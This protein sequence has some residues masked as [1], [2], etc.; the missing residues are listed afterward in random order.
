MKDSDPIL[1]WHIN[2]ALP[3]AMDI[4]VQARVATLITPNS[5]D[6]IYRQLDTNW[7]AWQ[8]Y[9]PG[10]K[11]ELLEDDYLYHPSVG[12]LIPAA[13]AWL[14]QEKIIVYRFQLICIVQPDN[15]FTVG[16]I[17]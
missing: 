2:S 11:W 6:P 9:P 4:L 7:S 3:E 10:M 12:T 14:G 5:V 13:M 16:R 17:V 8:V 15:S 1:D